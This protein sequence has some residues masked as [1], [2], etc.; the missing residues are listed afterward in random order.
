MTPSAQT[1]FPPVADHEN[2]TT[3]YA[4][5]NSTYEDKTLDQLPTFSR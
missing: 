2:K 3:H 4:F 1:K 5:M